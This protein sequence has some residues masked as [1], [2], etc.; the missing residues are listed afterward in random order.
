MTATT[1]LATLMERADEAM[2]VHG[3]A[4]ETEMQRRIEEAIRRG[5]DDLAVRDFDH[6]LQI[7]AYRRRSPLFGA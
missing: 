6:V 3:A 5:D 2:R 7:I 1:P 4:A